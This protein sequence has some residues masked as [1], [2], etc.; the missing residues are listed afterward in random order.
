M[1]DEVF[2]FFFFFSEDWA[3]E[4]NVTAAGLCCQIDSKDVSGSLQKLVELN[5]EICSN[6]T[7]C[8]WIVGV[9]VGWK[10]SAD[11]RRLLGSYT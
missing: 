1:C 11:F 7:I 8:V 10:G 2:F 5:E 3:G 9:A 4:L 6:L